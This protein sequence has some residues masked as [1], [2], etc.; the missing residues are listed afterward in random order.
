MAAVG[1]SSDSGA[2]ILMVCLLLKA[3]AIYLSSTC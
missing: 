1:G 3:I 2:P